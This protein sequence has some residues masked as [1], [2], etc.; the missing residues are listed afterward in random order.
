MKNLSIP[1]KNPDSW[2][3][4]KIK[5]D[6]DFCILNTKVKDLIKLSE[7]IVMENKYCAGNYQ[8]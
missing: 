8:R 2:D 1:P 6:F 3:M 7:D 5:R 4:Q